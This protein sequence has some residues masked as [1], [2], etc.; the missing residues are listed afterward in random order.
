MAK[1]IGRPTIKN[2]KEQ[3]NLTVNKELNVALTEFAEENG[4]SK[5]EY[6]EYLIKQDI[7]KPLKIN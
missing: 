6:I 1:K 5:S 4:L 2:K 7:K 3:L